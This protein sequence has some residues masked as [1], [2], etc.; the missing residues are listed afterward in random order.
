MKKLN[1]FIERV[2]SDKIIHFAFGG[3]IEA[4]LAIVG[5]SFGK[6]GCIIAMFVGIAVVYVISWWKETVDDKQDS[7]YDKKD[8]T[9][10]MYGV[11]AT[12]LFTFATFLL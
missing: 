3:W 1:E 10:A 5:W 4:L 9:W 7:P 8:I 12:L 2:S 6:V 11:L